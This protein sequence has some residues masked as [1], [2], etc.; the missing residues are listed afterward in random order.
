MGGGSIAETQRSGVIREALGYADA[1]YNLAHRL[2]GRAPDAE[3]LVQET[4][5]HALAALDRFTPGTNLKAWL[6]RILRNLVLDQAR[7]RV[8]ERSYDTVEGE[9]SVN[10][11]SDGACLR[12]D[13]ELERMRRLVG[14]EIEAALASLPEEARLT[15]LLDL[16][17]FSE[18]EV[19]GILECAPGTVK[20]RLA[21][22][23]AALRRLLADY[24][25]EGRR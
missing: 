1:L 23:R 13:L 16:E 8:P 21:R 12:N 2:C 11:V 5:S 6:F 3:D 7:R 9:E 18:A 24:A 15:V 17:G 19:A 25:R 22:A 20:S 4:Y 14:A 10:A